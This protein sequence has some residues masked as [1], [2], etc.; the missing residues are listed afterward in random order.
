MVVGVEVVVLREHLAAVNRNMAKSGF[1]Y[2]EIY[3][4]RNKAPRSGYL[5]P[6]KA[7]S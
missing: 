2:V 5:A 4:F 1:I 7:H 6:G 3:D